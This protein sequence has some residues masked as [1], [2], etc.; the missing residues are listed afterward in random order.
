MYYAYN[1]NRK[2]VQGSITLITS[3]IILRTWSV[4]ELY[5]VVGAS[6]SV[7]W[8]AGIAAPNWKIETQPKLRRVVIII[9]YCIIHSYYILYILYI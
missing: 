5:I 3:D 6:S 7:L 8:I 2:N 4:T 9:Y 1:H